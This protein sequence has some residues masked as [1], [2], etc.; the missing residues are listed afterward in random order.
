MYSLFN[1]KWVFLV[2]LFIFEVGSL[3]CGVSPNSIAL[4][5]GRAI[6]GFGS[7]GIFSGAIITIGETVVLERRP[8][9]FALVG[10]MYGIASVA[11]PLMGGAFTD[12][13]TWRWCFYINLPLGGIT[14]VGL[15][16][17]LRLKQKPEAGLS[18]SALIKKLDVVGTTIFI[19]AIVCALLALQ[20]GGSTYAWSDGRI[21]ALFVLFGAFLIAFVAIEIY[22]KENALVPPRIASQRT[23]AFACLFGALIGGSFFIFVYYV[24]IWVCRLNSIPL[25]HAYN[26]SSKPSRESALSLLASTRSRSF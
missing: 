18:W 16:T 12:R 20:W 21:I 2:A 6:A 15:L 9:F 3:I 5:L 22:L 8:I 14:A 11:G 24:P 4:I 13:V 10:G 7:G 19:G 17:L 1:V 23:I 26:R 25:A